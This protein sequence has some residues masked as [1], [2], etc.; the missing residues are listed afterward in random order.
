MIVSIFPSILFCNTSK[1]KKPGNDQNLGK[2]LK[3]HNGH[4]CIDLNRRMMS[5]S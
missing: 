2:S 1:P 5:M 4:P 3:I